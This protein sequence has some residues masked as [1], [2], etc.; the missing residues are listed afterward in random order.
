MADKYVSI[1]EAWSRFCSEEQKSNP[2]LF[3]PQNWRPS[4][5]PGRYELEFHF[6]YFELAP[7]P[8]NGL[9][10]QPMRFFWT[11]AMEMLVAEFLHRVAHPLRD[12]TDIER[13]RGARD[14][15]AIEE[16]FRPDDESFLRMF[17]ETYRY[18]IPDT[19]SDT[20]KRPNLFDGGPKSWDAV[21]PVT[22]FPIAILFEREAFEALDVVKG[23]SDL[24]LPVSPATAKGKAACIQWLIGQRETGPQPKKKG[25][26]RDEAAKKFGVGPGQ[27]NDCWAHAGLVAPRDSWGKAGARRKKS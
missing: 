16:W 13:P 15:I 4:N 12:K 18:R 1:I 3:E 7:K 26:M 23:W 8:I 22:S 19:A 5:G 21:R 6:D 14:R 25:D 24:D 20:R 27:F 17:F 2:A 9:E 11:K 10:Y